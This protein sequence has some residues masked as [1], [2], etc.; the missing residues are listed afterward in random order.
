MT[1]KDTT[2]R[3][4]AAGQNAEERAST[5]V[6]GLDAIP[7]GG[8][9]RTRVYL[10][11]GTPGTGK[12]TF[13]LRFLIAGAERGERGLHITLSETAEELEAVV[14]S[15]HWSLDGIDLFELVDDSGRD[16]DAEQSI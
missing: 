2:S 1:D 6:D 7:G 4:D 15:H 8:L 10:L 3:T 12:T 11:E 14:R 16:P 9:T 13:A 5:G